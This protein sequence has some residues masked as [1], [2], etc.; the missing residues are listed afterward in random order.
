MKTIKYISLILLLGCATF[1]TATEQ[2]TTQMPYLPFE[3]TSALPPSGTFLP[4]AA[5]DG[6]VTS[7]DI[8][9]DANNTPSGPRRVSIYNPPADPFDDPVGD[10]LLPLA[11][12]ATAYTI[13]TLTRKKRTAN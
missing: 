8:I 10:A 7:A 13:Y 11:L 2:T 1:L 4:N 12:L 6:V 9:E 3:S 5:M